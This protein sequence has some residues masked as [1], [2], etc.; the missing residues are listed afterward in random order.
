MTANVGYNL[1]STTGSTPTL[2]DPAVLTSFGFNYHRPTAALDLSLAKGVTF[3]TAWGYYD[4]N[5]KYLPT[6]LLARDFQ[7]NSATLSMRYEF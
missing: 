5:E 1:T 7:A 3:R 6:P 4:Y 2:A